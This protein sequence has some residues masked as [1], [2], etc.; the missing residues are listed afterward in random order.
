[1]VFG[2][3]LLGFIVAIVC[4]CLFLLY[5]KYVYL[6]CCVLKCDSVKLFFVEFSVLRGKLWGGYLW[7]EGYAVRAAGVVTCVK[8][9][10]YINRS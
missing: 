6:R 5:R 8:I 7:L 1:V 3:S 2:C 10:E 9:G 4:M